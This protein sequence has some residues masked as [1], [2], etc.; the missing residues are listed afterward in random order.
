MASGE[1]V[2]HQSDVAL[3]G[4]LNLEL[5]RT[6]VSSYRA[7][8]WFGRTWS[9]TLDQRLESHA[10]SYGVIFRSVYLFTHEGSAMSS[11]SAR[12]ST[13]GHGTSSGS[14]RNSPM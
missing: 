3:D 1:M 11:C 13:T 8:R 7:G 12:Y 9:S 14:C 6:H 10:W 2:L 4:I 5:S